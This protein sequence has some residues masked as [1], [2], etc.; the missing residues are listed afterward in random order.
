M[1]NQHKIKLSPKQVSVCVLLI[2]HRFLWRNVGSLLSTP[3]K[4]AHYT[5]FM[6]CHI[7][8]GFNFQVTS[9][10]SIL[11]CVCF[12][13]LLGSLSTSKANGEDC[14][15]TWRIIMKYLGYL[16]ISASTFVC[17]RHSSIMI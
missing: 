14:V 9:I 1:C 12:F 5:S 15:C 8:S 13:F 10:T 6:K 16:M 3:Y 4:F 17:S 11:D 2:V 7:T